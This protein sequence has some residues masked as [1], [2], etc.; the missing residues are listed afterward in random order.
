MP[1][2]PPEGRFTDEQ[3]RLIDEQSV[4][5]PPEDKWFLEQ[6]VL[7][8]NRYRITRK[9]LENPWRAFWYEVLFPFFHWR[10]YWERHSRRMGRWAAQLFAPYLASAERAA[11]QAGEVRDAVRRVEEMA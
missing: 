4:G 1:E 5:W 3:R 10:L 6:E 8:L 2:F 7:C 9:M 11:E